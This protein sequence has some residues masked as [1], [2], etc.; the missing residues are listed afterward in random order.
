MKYFS[1]S[2]RFS[3]NERSIFFFSI[4]LEFG[5]ILN[6]MF[7]SSDVTTFAGLGSSLFKRYTCENSQC[8]I[9]NRQ[10]TVYRVSVWG[11]HLVH[12]YCISFNWGLFCSYV[13]CLYTG[14]GHYHELFVFTFTY[15]IASCIAKVPL[16]NI[17]REFQVYF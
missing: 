11:V 1:S 14:I 13:V 15:T 7:H 3:L 16:V 9:L 12:W 10:R 2:W 17:D 8:P 6:I 5:T 4:D